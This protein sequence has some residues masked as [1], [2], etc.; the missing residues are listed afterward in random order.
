MTCPTCSHSRSRVV[1]TRSARRRHECL[2][3][4][5]RFS[6]IEQILPGTMAPKKIFRPKKESGASWVQ[7]I[8]QKLA[9]PDIS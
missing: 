2:A 8:L 4:G 3:C 7:R 5:I 9:E 1:D 6:T